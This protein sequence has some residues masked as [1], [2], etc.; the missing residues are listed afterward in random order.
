L[1]TLL[2]LSFLLIYTD[3]SRQKPLLFSLGRS[4]AVAAPTPPYNHAPPTPL[5]VAADHPNLEQ[6]NILLVSSFFPV[7]NSKH[8]KY[9]R[10]DYK[11]WLN[12]FLSR[13]DKDIYLF[14]SPEWES[15]IKRMR[16]DLPIHINTTYSSPF[17]IPPLNDRREDYDRMYS[18]DREKHHHS[19]ELY[20]IWS[21]KPFLLKEGLSNMRKQKEYKYAFWVNS[22]TFRDQHPWRSWPAPERVEEIWKE[23][24][25]ASGTSADELLFFPFAGMPHGSMIFWSEG[26][27]PIDNDFSQG[28]FFGGMPNAISWW[29]GAYYAYR[30]HWLKQDHFV[31]KDESVNNAILLLY[32]RKIIGTWLFDPLAPAAVSLLS[33][34]PALSSYDAK[35][36]PPPSLLDSPLGQCLDHRHYYLFF[37]AFSDERAVMADLWLRRW[38]WMWPWQWVGQVG[39]RKEPCRLTRVL[40][41]ERTLKERF[42]GEGWSSPKSDVV[43]QT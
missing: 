4:D 28:S 15:T 23:G 3:Y 9:S 29:C 20:A 8:S 36:P 26:M 16:G 21:S 43:V 6:A 22:D 31:G 11:R 40:P 30:D 18:K 12:L 5:S 7:S 34:S 14:T 35:H 39:V 33:S 25:E 17:D 10:Q 37:L 41:L 24:S 13:I 27:G 38:R 2:I 42:W 19:T 1:F 32:S